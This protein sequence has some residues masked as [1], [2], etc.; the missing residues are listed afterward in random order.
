[1]RLVLCTA[2]VLVGALGSVG[3]CDDDPEDEQAAYVAR[4]DAICERGRARMRS[5]PEAANSTE[6]AEDLRE[7]L[8]AL[9]A[10]PPAVAAL[11]P[12]VA[13]LLAVVTWGAE[14]FQLAGRAWDD[15]HVSPEDLRALG[16]EICG[17]P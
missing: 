7:E 11:A 5:E 8:R 10:P 9:G 1:M 4:A 17:T 16:F 13:D 15:R 2:L 3:A 6:V 14:A 12:D